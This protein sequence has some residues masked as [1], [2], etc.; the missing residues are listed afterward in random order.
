MT[1]YT[2]TFHTEADWAEQMM[3]A[4]RSSAAGVA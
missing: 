4:S 1:I 3:L 2:A